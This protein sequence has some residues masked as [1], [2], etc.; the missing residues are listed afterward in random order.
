[1]C[2]VQLEDMFGM[3][4]VTVFPRT[5]E[6][7]PDI[8]V[9]DTVV[10][11]RGEVQVRRDEPGILCNNVTEFKAVEEEMNRKQYMVWLKVQLT[12]N[13]DRSVSN[14]IMKVQNIKRY[15]SEKPGRDH[16]EILVANG[17]WEMRLTP[18]DNTMGPDSSELVE[19]ARRGA[20]HRDGR[21]Q[22]SLA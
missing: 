3:I 2:I 5:Y 14:D 10:I 4:T 8:W 12:G 17:E 13:D 19:E 9:E 15:L 22:S 6:E 16:Y 20:R 21:S 11:V 7:K 18:Q 1:M